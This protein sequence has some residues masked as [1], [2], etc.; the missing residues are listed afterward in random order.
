M[1]NYLK[2]KIIIPAWDMIKDD[3]NAKKFYFIPGTLSII[4]LTGILVYQTIYTYVK[5]IGNNQDKVLKTILRFLETDLGKE[6]LIAGII[7]LVFYFLLTPIFEAGLVKYIH[8][9]YKGGDISKS[10]AFGQGL[11]KFLQTFEYNN[12]FSEFKLL[13]ILN[14]Y[15]FVIRFTGIEYIKIVS[16]IFLFLLVFGIIINI[17]FSYAKFFLILEDKNVFQAVGESTKLTILNPKTTIKLF[18]LIFALNLRVII[19][20]LVFL[21]FPIIIVS[22]ITYISMKFLLFVTV[23]VTIV[24]FVIII[25]FM[26]YLTAVLDVFKVSLW[27]HAYDYGKKKMEI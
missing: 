5:I 27:Y 15:L 20:F 3:S 16:Y 18:F 4:F 21:I 8:I 19:N 12:M 22:A 9:K 10:E 1:N 2:D 25:L 17:L 23:L 7:F 11:Y 6:V 24:L 13:S 26:G 14:G